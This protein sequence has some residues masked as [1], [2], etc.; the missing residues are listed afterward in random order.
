M[1]KPDSSSR[2]NKWQ[3]R[4]AY[5]VK[6]K[7]CT[8]RDFPSKVLEGIGVRDLHIHGNALYEVQPDKIIVIKNSNEISCCF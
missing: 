6:W 7:D 1:H 4:E 8:Y 3:K 5:D 2:V